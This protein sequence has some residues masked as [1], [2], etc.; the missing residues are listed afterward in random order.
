MEAKHEEV[1]IKHVGPDLSVSCECGKWERKA[2][3][4]SVAQ[5]LWNSHRHQAAKKP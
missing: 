3:C 1:T 4:M 5:D 2:S